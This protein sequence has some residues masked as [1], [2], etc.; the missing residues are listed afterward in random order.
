MQLRRWTS[1]IR[2]FLGDSAGP[3]AVEYAV[4]LGLILLA[5]IASI[6]VVGGGSGNLWESNSTQI[7]TAVNGS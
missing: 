5:A 3:T 4:M 7:D 2:H 6:S 1:R